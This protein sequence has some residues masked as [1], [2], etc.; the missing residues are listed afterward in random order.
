MNI[1]RSAN[2][3]VAFF[4]GVLAFCMSLLD[5]STPTVRRMAGIA[6]P[7]SALIFF[8]SGLNPSYAVEPIVFLPS[9]IELEPIS[10]YCG[11]LF[12]F[13]YCVVFIAFGNRVFATRTAAY[14]LMIQ[15]LVCLALLCE[16]TELFF[17]IVTAALII[18]L[19]V[20]QTDVYQVSR[21]QDRFVLVSFASI[22]V[23]VIGFTFFT[24]LRISE[25]ISTFHELAAHAGN[26]PRYLKV[27]SSVLMM[28][29]LGAFPFHFWVKPLFAAPARYGLAVITRLNIGFLVWCKLY[30]LIYSGDWLLDLLLT[31][32]CGANLLYSAFL[33]FGERRLS[34][35]VSTLYLF[36]VPLLILAVK[37]SG[38]EAV[39]DFLL[40]FANIIVAISGLLV[41]LGMLRD[42]LGA[43]ELDRGSGLGIAYPFL[44]IAFLVC[45]LSLVGFPGTLGFISSEVMLHHFAES[46]W[47]VAVCFIVTLALNGYSSFRIFGESFY[48][49]PA[50]SFRKAFQP[51]VREKVAVVLVLLFLCVS[52]LSGR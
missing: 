36:H 23:V 7:F 12:N 45:I 42:R 44:G 34:Q 50:K 3:L 10:A 14:W 30:P 11:M 9:W 51:L 2:I 31:Y 4:P 19:K 43:E 46:T 39:P 29:L 22:L 5:L 24:L 35:I 40:D 18:H 25:G 52:G 33:L 41:I 13:M 15:L 6:L 20:S 27:L 47:P 26:L 17:L 16:N 1:V 21:K 8:V 48:G 28:I 49:D 32:G 37:I 38:N